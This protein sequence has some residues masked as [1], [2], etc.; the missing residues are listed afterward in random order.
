MF[1]G[2]ARRLAILNA[3]TVIIVIA[4]AGGITWLALRTALD[5]EVDNALRD[6]IGTYIAN[7]A[8]FE[9][10]SV[11]ATP[12]TAEEGD[13][14]HHGDD[15]DDEHDREVVG[16]GDTLLFVVDRSGDVTFNSRGVDLEDL[17]VEDA[18]ERALAGRRDSRSV[19]LDESGKVRVLTVPLREGGQITGAVQA[20]R[21]LEEHDRELALVG[22][23]T[24]LGI[25]LGALIA[26][27][28]GLYLSRRAMIPIDD[29]FGR[30]R[31]FVAD[32]SHELRTPLTL[33]RANAELSLLDPGRPLN[34]SL[35]NILTEVDRTDRLVDDLLLLARVDA[36]RL[37]LHSE[38]HRLG[39]LVADAAESMRPLFEDQQTRLTVATDTPVDVWADGDRIQQVVRS[40]L[41]NALKH[42]SG[43]QVDVSAGSEG[44]WAVVTIRD[45]GSGI[46]SEALPHIFDRFYRI[47]T[48][49]SR[50]AGGTG[51]GLSIAKAIVEAH[52]G[53][54]SITSE[55]DRG[56][57]VMF[58]LPV[59]NR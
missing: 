46:P 24:L 16:S 10:A 55:P 29:A 9:H 32:A 56:T 31:S 38:R 2:V 4:L 52:G 44:R 27:P 37:E 50:A 58:R 23:M 42:T 35:A 6:R 20:L 21:S 22:W 12:T 30:Q 54:I 13:E 39:S 47:D 15:D 28:A 5:D 3:L 14:E 48:A 57:T 11:T 18:I 51:L 33:I 43:G 17:P 40:L 53:E 26:V 45:T 59:T 41:D 34:E 25:T 8:L 19:T 36:G 1:R 49:R 7:P